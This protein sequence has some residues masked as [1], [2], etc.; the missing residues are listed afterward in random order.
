MRCVL[1][2]AGAERFAA[3]SSRI[4]FSVLRFDSASSS[5]PPHR[6][7]DAGMV[8]RLTQPPLAYV[9]KLSQAA[10][11]V[12]KFAGSIGLRAAAV[13]AAAGPV[14]AA[15]ATAATSQERRWS[16]LG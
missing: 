13:C 2:P 10:Q 1:L 14:A 9:K 4:C 3:A 6:E 11:V 8:E 12:S 5:K 16:I 15:T 7:S